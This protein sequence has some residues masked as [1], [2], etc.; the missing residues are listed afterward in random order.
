MDRMTDEQLAAWEVEAAE[1]CGL[2]ADTSL[3]LIA[4]VRRLRE[5]ELACNSLVENISLGPKPIYVIGTKRADGWEEDISSPLITRIGR[6]LEEPK[7]DQK[8]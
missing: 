8:R 2:D 4:D 5:L 6:L 7:D 3:A 1:S